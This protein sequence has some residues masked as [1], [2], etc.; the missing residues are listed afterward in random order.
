MTYYL[1]LYWQAVEQLS[2]GEASVRL[3]PGI[4]AHVTG[5]LFAGAVS[6]D[7]VAGLNSADQ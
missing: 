1:P 2:A 5:S 3:L 6:L 7:G 4:V